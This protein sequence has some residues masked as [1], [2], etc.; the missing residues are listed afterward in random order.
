MF[1]RRSQTVSNFGWRRE[2]N[3]RQN[4][5]S[6]F[7]GGGGVDFCKSHVS[8]VLSSYSASCSVERQDRYY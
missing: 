1:S 8:V 4:R 3:L 7:S 5:K 2:K 6:E